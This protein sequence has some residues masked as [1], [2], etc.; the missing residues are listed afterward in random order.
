MLCEQFAVGWICAL[1]IEFLVACELLD[2]EYSRNQVA[3]IHPRDPNV[4][5]FGRINTHKVVITCLA[6]GRYG[7]NSAAVAAERMRNSFPARK[8]IGF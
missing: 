4:Y 6:R 2:E 1:E 5:I 3:K 8:S 7:V